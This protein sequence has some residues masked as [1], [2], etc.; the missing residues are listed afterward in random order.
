MQ[1]FS[2]V[3]TVVR[4]FRKPDLDMKNT[5]NRTFATW[6]LWRGVL[7]PVC[8]NLHIQCNLP[9]MAD[10]MHFS[11]VFCTLFTNTQKPP[12]VRPIWNQN[13]NL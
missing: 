9:Y 2:L 3:F 11:E 8:E 7:I 1:K 10:K 13:E 4:T 5:G 6:R 12:N